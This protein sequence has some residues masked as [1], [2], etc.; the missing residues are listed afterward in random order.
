MAANPAMA[1]T[2][3]PGQLPEAPVSWTA[4]YISPEGFECLLTLRGADLASVMRQAKQATESMAK[5]G[6]K[7]AEHYRSAAQAPG[8]GAP[9]QGT[10]PA[11]QAPICP[12]HNKPMKRNSHNNGWFCPVKI[13]ENDGTGKPV[14]CKQQ[15]RD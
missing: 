8:A 2:L 10:A 4:K 11:I 7:P 3:Q 14:Y 15:I 9:A 12:T 5:A 13:A 1:P 6:C